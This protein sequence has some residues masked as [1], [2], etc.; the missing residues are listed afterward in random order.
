MRICVFGLGEAGS[1]FASDLATAGAEVIGF[2]PAE[3]GTPQ[4]VKRAVHPALAVRN[5]ELILSLTGEADSK[6]AMLQAIEAIDTDALY[7]DLATS[8]PTVKLDLE[9]MAERKGFAFAD[10]AL[11]AMVPGHGL[12]TPSLAS[13]PGANRY[14]ETINRFGG[15]VEPLAAATGVAAGRKLLRSVMMKGFAAV[16]LE[17][18]K[19]GAA[20]DDLGW[21]WRNLSSEIERADDDWLRRIVLGSKVHARRRHSEMISATAMLQ[22]LGVDP[23]MTSATAASLAGLLDDESELPE[24]PD[25]QPA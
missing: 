22:A 18:V 7:A 21:L 13:G 16:I 17:A 15:Y 12:A 3:V 19:A 14:A 11:L 5:A 9:A 1:L 2:D 25:N 23:V 8:S 10:V 4:G 6:L 24:L 20:A